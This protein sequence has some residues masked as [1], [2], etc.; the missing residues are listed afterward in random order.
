MSLWLLLLMFLLLAALTGTA[1]ATPHDR[2]LGETTRGTLWLQADN[3]AYSS[4]PGLATE[5]TIEVTAMVARATVRQRF[6][7]PG[8][9][10]G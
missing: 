4:A 8:Q 1:N 7:N 2:V 9:H 3:G 10:V 5:V 6:R